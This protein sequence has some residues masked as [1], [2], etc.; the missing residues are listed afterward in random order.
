MALLE[1]MAGT[2]RLA[3]A[4]ER[5]LGVCGLEAKGFFKVRNCFGKA[6]YQLWHWNDLCTILQ[7]GIAPPIHLFSS[8]SQS[9]F[10]CNGDCNSS[11]E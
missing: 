9:V 4:N 8:A 5:R 7:F 11:S 6:D 10:K 2:T 1:N 3:L